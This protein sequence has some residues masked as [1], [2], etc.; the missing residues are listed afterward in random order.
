MG[1]QT[2]SCASNLTSHMTD[3]FFR[4]VH[5]D[6]VTIEVSRS[7][8]IDLALECDFK[9]T[10]LLHLNVDQVEELIEALDAAMEKYK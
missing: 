7:D 4:T 5:M 10:I 3:D 1:A 8:T 9:G 6:G 2:P